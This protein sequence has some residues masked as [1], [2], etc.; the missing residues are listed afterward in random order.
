MNKMIKIPSR[1]LGLINVCELARKF[2]ETSSWIHVRISNGT[3]PAPSKKHGLKL[4]YS[5][6]ELPMLEKKLGKKN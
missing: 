5:V 3:I 6:E 4:Y 2:G 1:E